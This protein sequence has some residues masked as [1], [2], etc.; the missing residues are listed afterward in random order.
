LIISVEA[1]KKHIGTLCAKL[2]VSNR[3]EA[4]ARSTQLNLLG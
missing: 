4:A 3:T 2:G 1:V